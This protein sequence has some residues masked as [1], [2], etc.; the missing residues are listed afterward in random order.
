MEQPFTPEQ[1]DYLKQRVFEYI[2]EM[3][4]RFEETIMDINKR[5]NQDFDQAC[6]KFP[7]HS[8]INPRFLMA[9]AVDNLF[10]Q[11]HQGD[12]KMAKLIVTMLAR[13]AEVTEILADPEG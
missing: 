12:K 1:L 10:Q 13:Q 5:A 8:A 7:E 6:I 2:Q 9:T 11:L 3:L 4:T